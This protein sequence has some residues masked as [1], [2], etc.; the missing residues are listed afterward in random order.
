MKRKR[1]KEL[2]PRL[3][4]DFYDACL[5][6]K[7]TDKIAACFEVDWATVVDWMK[8]WPELAMAKQLA[9]ERR[10]GRNTLSGYVFSRLSREAQDAWDKITFWDGHTS[11]SEKIEDLLSSQPVSLRQ[12]L[13]IHALVSSNFDVS[14]ACRLVNTNLA[15]INIWKQDLA[16]R[17]LIDEIQWHKKNFFESALIGLV[18]QN[19]AG[20]VMFVNRT[21]NKDRGY[22]E[23]V[24]I[25]HTGQVDVNTGF[26]FEE[27]DLDLETKEKILDAI[28]RKKELKNGGVIDVEPASAAPQLEYANRQ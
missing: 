28:R 26:D 16:F 17:Q 2:T 13:F 6:E 7:K 23:K 4:L 22:G 8:K 14:S 21:M 5:R 20:A 3:L 12:E 11:A 9:E 25:Q 15:T 27:L 19:H 1:P 18:E 10:K 24:E